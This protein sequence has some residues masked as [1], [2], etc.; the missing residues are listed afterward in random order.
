MRGLIWLRRI[1]ALLLVVAC[2]VALTGAYILVDAFARLLFIGG[3]TTFVPLYLWID[4]RL[5]AR[6]QRIVLF[7]SFIRQDPP[8]A[9]G[10]PAQ[11][12]RRAA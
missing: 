5:T 10:G 11:S 7:E 3:Y 4:H 2:L 1:I 6:L 9:S 12:T 8:S